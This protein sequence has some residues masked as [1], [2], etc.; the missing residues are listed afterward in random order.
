VGVVTAIAV[1]MRFAGPRALWLDE[2]LTVSISRLPVPKLLQALRHDGSPPGYYLLLHYW[3]GIF[4]TG[5]RAVR[6]LAGVLSVAAL[7]VGWRLG[8]AVG[9]RRVAATFV[10]VLACNPFALR[11]GTEN[12]MYSLVMLLATIAAL[13]VVRSLQR[14]TFWRLFSFGLACGLMLLTHYWALYLIAA[15]GAFLLAFSLRGPLR[16]N[17]RLALVALCS[18]CLLFAPWLPSFAFQLQHT[19]TPWSTPATP[20]MILWAF[21]EFAGWE[22]NPG[23]VVFGLYITAVVV[24]AAAVLVATTRLPDRIVRLLGWSRPVPGV[25]WAAPAAGVF[26]LTMLVA[27]VGG[28]VASAAFAYRYGSVVLPFVV[29]VVA[30]GIVALSR[31]RLGAVA[32]AALLLAIAVFGTTGGSA[33]I[34][35]RRT[36]ATAVAA[37]I[38]RDARPGDVVA[39]CPDQLGPAV[40]RLLPSRL[41]TQVT[42]PRFDDPSRINWV[43]YAQINS[44]TNPAVFARELLNLAGPHQLWLVWEAGY[45]TLGQSCQQIRNTLR[46]ARPDWSD[47]VRS[48]PGTYYEHE[49]LARFLAE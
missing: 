18:G 30:L 27:M 5:T 36:Q 8:R 19:G 40:S 41:F 35:G 42:F 39:F 46:V 4:G 26:L 43:D 11:Y 6:A 32:G 37:G 47:P 14:P 21:G 13:A 45:R 29:L 12:R 28:M 44:A 10:V 17:A 24:I 34:L 1:V 20:S 33:E 9:G 7:P 22:R 38:M 23:M 2:A 49:N 15:L 25:R 16:V 48:R 3:M 31:S